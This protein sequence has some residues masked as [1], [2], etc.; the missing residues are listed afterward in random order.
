MSESEKQEIIGPETRSSSDLVAF[1]YVLGR[2]K[3]SNGEIEGVI[4]TVQAGQGVTRIFSNGYLAQWAQ[5]AAARLTT[6]ERGFYDRLRDVAERL[7]ETSDEHEIG[8]ELAEQ[9]GWA[10]LLDQEPKEPT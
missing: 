3:L 1:L 8:R 2:D 9:Y 5:N 6:R 4:E 7:L 10:D